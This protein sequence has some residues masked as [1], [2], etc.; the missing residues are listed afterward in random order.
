MGRASGGPGIPGLPGGGEP[1]FRSGHRG[2]L[3][4]DDL[5]VQVVERLGAEGLALSPFAV[6]ATLQL[7]RRLVDGA[8]E[9]AAE[10]LYAAVPAELRRAGVLLPAGQVEQVI[11]AYARLVA[12][13]DIRDVAE[14]RL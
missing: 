6:K 5:V 11:R 10:D 7:T 9:V 1:S 12:E 14:I 8:V 3:T 2:W 4:L 13:L